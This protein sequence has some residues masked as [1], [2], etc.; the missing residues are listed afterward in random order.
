MKE[1]GKTV[2]GRL[3]SAVP[4]VPPPISNPSS[5]LT[6]FRKTLPAT[7]LKSTI[8]SAINSNRVILIA[9]ETGS[10]KTTQVV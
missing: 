4:Q 9:G 3:H 10:G 6:N 5:E 8:T 7:A 1:L 2:T